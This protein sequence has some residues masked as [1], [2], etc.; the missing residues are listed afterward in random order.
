M[1]EVN[2]MCQGQEG[3]S[4]VHLRLTPGCLLAAVQTCVGDEMRMR[5]PVPG[6]PT[7]PPRPHT[8]S[9]RRRGLVRTP[10]ALYTP[11]TVMRSPGLAR[12]TRS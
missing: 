11:V 4:G 2:G 12:S 10:V 5:A 6:D 9:S 8:L 7:L 3:G 1:G